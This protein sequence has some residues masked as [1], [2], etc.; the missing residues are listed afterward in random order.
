MRLTV[1]PAQA[2]ALLL[3]IPHA[4]C[5]AGIQNRW[6]VDPNGNAA[7]EAV[8]WLYCWAKT[9]Q[10]SDSARLASIEVFDQIF[11]VSF[12]QFD[13]CLNDH[14]WAR[15]NRYS[16]KAQKNVKQELVTRL[17]ACGLVV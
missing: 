8:L 6:H 14:D 1:S 4:T 9:G 12:A 11:S 7:A 3:S 2:T 16:E 13:Q 15:R 17:T 10:G 5:Q